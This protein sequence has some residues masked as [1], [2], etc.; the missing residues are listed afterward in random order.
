MKEF[1]RFDYYNPYS[2]QEVTSFYCGIISKS[3]ENTQ[4]IRVSKISE[5]V[6]KENASKGI[7]VVSVKD[8]ILA[9]KHNY[10]FIVTWIQ[11][12]WPEEMWL[13][14]KDLPRYIL[15]SI[16]EKR[17]IKCSNFVFYCSEDMKRHFEK[18][19]HIKAK[20][21]F[22]MPCFNEEIDYTLIQ[23]KDY[24]QNIFVYAGGMDKWQ[25]FSK[26]AS[27]YKKIEDQIPNCL[28]KVF[29]RDQEAAKKILDTLHVKN[30]CVDYLPTNQLRKELAKAKFG[31]CIR[32]DIEVNRV[33]T[34]TKL[35]NYVAY[36]IFPIYSKCLRS[37]HKQAI[38]SAY[39]LCI[40]SDSFFE[41][42]EKLCTSKIKNSDVAHD[43]RKCFGNY[44]S[45]DYYLNLI[46]YE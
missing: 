10:G 45:G 13:Q 4:K 23:E 46:V 16:R 42:V 28:F 3:I 35:S 31:F 24:G 14:R 32:D 11:G 9:K 39:S 26:I 36:G 8:A 43:Y 5:I 7:I 30:Y 18:K 37:F 1:E 40:D 17:G 20:R 29:A 44:Y 25:C 12:I 21:D 41:D 38:N 33:A 19:Y 27:V 2:N 22:I 34:P 6:G 15:Y